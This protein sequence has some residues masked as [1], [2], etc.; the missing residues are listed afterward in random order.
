MKNACRTPEASLRP[1]PHQQSS[2]VIRQKKD[3]KSTILCQ[4]YPLSPQSSTDANILTIGLAVYYASFYRLA[5][6]FS[7]EKSIF[8]A[9]ELFDFCR[10]ATKLKGS[11]IYTAKL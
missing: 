11:E 7:A 3:E 2:R 4:L 8:I 10:I 5:K 9:F 6:V 1:P